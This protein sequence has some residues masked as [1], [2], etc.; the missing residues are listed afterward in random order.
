MAYVNTYLYYYAAIIMMIILEGNLRGG[1]KRT[2]SNR[3]Y[4]RLLASDILMLLAGSTDSLLLLRVAGGHSGSAWLHALMAGTSDLAYFGVLGNFILY[5]DTYVKDDNTPIDR[6]AWAGGIISAVYGLF[7][8][9][10]GFTGMIYTQDAEEVLKGPAYVIG[11]VGGYMVSALI[12]L[13]YIKRIRQFIFSEIIGFALFIFIPFAGSL[14]KNTVRGVTLMP[15]LVTISVVIIQSF[16]NIKR[17]L[18]MR[19]Q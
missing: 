18:I 15:L 7:W 13:I 11:Q 16:V 6:I 10:S 14:V 8:F 9:I 17:E 1:L 5:L 2:R 4:Y 3:F 12:I 19:E